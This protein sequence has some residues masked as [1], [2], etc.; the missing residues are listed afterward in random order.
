MGAI[1]EGIEAGSQPDLQGRTRQVL[2][3]SFIQR[4]EVSQLVGA[5]PG[6]VDARDARTREL[7]EQ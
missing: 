4:L 6:N 5:Y 7:Q 2:A 3:F 1:V